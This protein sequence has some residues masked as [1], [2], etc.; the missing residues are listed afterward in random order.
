MLRELPE[1]ELSDTSDYERWYFEGQHAAVR[2]GGQGGVHGE[3]AGGKLNAHRPS[4]SGMTRDT[5]RR[6]SST[7]NLDIPAP[8]GVELPF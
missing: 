7:P 2:S 8:C 5:T 4:Q 1:T 3:R 6:S